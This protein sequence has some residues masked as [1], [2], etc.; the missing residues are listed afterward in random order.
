VIFSPETIDRRRQTGVLLSLASHAALFLVAFLLTLHWERV[1]PVYRESR[2]CTAA[3]YWTGNMGTS[4]PSAPADHPKRSQPSPIPVPRSAR[5]ENPVRLRQPRA[6]EKPAP[7]QSRLAQPGNPSPQ[8]QQSTGTGTGTEDAEPAFPTYFPRPSVTD[9]S[10]LP[11]VEQ[12]IIIHVT[13]SALGDVTDEKLVQGLGNSLDQI[14]LD[15]VKSWRFHPAT[16]DGNAVAS[17]EELV[18]P[19]NRDYPSDDSPAAES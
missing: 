1:R 17:V 7:A 4:N 13:I 8:R 14:V 19:F 9:R 12:K 2:C 3:L 5:I 11:P 6:P 10:L 16:L 15:T 18:F